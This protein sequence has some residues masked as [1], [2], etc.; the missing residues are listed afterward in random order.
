MYFENWCWQGLSDFCRV[1]VV[2][3]FV[4]NPVFTG[5]DISLLI[6]TDM[7]LQNEGFVSKKSLMDS[8]KWEEERAT[9][10]LVCRI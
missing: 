4:L 10:A 6:V 2:A 9:R 1:T 7:F 3:N 8:L 5:S